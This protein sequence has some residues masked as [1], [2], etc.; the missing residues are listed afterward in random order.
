MFVD[1]PA[2]RH[3]NSRPGLGLRNVGGGYDGAPR[4]AFARA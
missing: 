4:V 2:G 1:T 3:R